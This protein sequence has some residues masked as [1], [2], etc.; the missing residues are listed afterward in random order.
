MPTTA[1]LAPTA[2][3]FVAKPDLPPLDDGYWDPLWA[4]Y[5]DRGLAVVV[6]GGYGLDQ[7]YAYKELEAACPAG[8][9]RWRFR[10]GAYRRPD[11]RPLRF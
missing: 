7:G 5:A 2:P 3:G 11:E 4:L 9:R 10:R 6:H 8:G 1:S